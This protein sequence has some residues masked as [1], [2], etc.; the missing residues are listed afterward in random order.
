[1]L[2]TGAILFRTDMKRLFNQNMET[3]K[4]NFPSLGQLESLSIANFFFFVQNVT[5]PRVFLFIF[6]FLVTLFVVIYCSNRQKDWFPVFLLVSFLNP[7]P[8]GVETSKTARNAWWCFRCSLSNRAKQGNWLQKAANNTA[9]CRNSSITEHLRLFQYTKDL[10]FKKAMYKLDLPVDMKESAA[11]ERR[12][13][14]EM[15]RQSRI[16]N[17]RVRTIGVRFRLLLVV[18]ILK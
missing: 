12:R 6:Y 13:N 15:Q 9:C 14:R 2:K 11:I 17:A 18:K 7:E 5:M 3:F 8:M 4:F 10:W 16:F 1:M